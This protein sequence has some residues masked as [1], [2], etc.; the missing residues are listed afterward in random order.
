MG[1]RLYTIFVPQVCLSV[2]KPEL[3]ILKA[4]PAP[5]LNLERKKMSFW[6][7]LIRKL[8]LERIGTILECYNKLGNKN[9]L[10]G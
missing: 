3:A 6:T 1:F 8:K 2:K 7:V 10:S 9:A 4:A 5:A